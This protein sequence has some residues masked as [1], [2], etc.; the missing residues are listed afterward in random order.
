[1]KFRSLLALAAVGAAALSVP[2]GAMA[3]AKEQ[4]FPALV[5]R[6][7]AYAPNGVPFANGY[8]DYL[9]L[10]NARGG[11]NG[12]KVSWEECET[13]YAT[14]RGVECYERLKGKNGGATV[15]HPLSTGITFALT[16]KVTADKIPLIT[17]GY[18]RSESTDGNVFLWNFPLTGTYWDAADILVQHV[19]KKEGGL[20][21]LKGKKIALVYHDSPYGKE[22]I[23]LLEE[24]AKM[25]GFTLQLL[26]VAHPGVEQK[27]TWLQIRQ[28]R[29]D[30]VFLWGWGVMN[31]TALKEAQAT[32]YPRDKMYGVW[33]AAAEPDAK[34]VGE[35]A[36]GYNGLTLQHGAEP[37]SAVVKEML[38][39]VHAKGQGTGPKE[40]VGQVLY[41]RGLMAGMLS[42]EG[43]RRA[44]E[45]YGKGKVMTGEQ[46]R[47]G[48][49]NLAL[50]Q[51][52]LDALG[53]KGVL[54]PIST[55]C[56]DHRGE[57]WS[58]IHTWDGSK[59]VFS[60]DWYQADQSVI[61]PMIKTAAD[62]Y[63]A[64]K[65]IERRSAA[66]CK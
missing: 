40:E 42:V 59:W 16:E 18:G 7:G 1:M 33:W 5:Y 57:V 66:D 44:Q 50:D 52:K 31:G 19:G 48:Y 6:T 12:V 15:I 26:P 22:P 21:K 14:D 51:A 24:R 4:F 54:R 2:L 13:G 17:A 62:K 56:A 8:I 20:D 39:K 10:T 61:K 9:K 60:S 64:E 37:N 49:E 36:K 43:V 65:K 47:W 53:F 34:D 46:A 29:P 55:S 23:A 41:M 3:Q 25:H 27:A 38:E 32:G 28:N 63:A 35:G 11:I 58:R 30:Y 45:R